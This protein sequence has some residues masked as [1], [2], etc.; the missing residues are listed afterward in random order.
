MERIRSLKSEVSAQSRALS[1][2]LRTAVLDGLAHAVKTPLTT[3]IVSSSGL[4]EVGSLTPLQ[5]ELADVIES[6]ASYLAEVTDKLLRTASLESRESLVQLTSA[7]I[8]VI[9]DSAISDLSLAYDTTRIHVEGMPGTPIEADPELL[10]MT[11]LQVLENALKYSPDS[12]PVLISFS[13]TKEEL[14]CSVYNH[15]SFIP[16]SEQSLIFERYYRGTSTAHKAN[17]T[18]IGLSVAQHAVEAHGGRI[19]VESDAETGTTFHI[20][21]PATPQGGEDASRVRTDR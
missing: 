13:Q 1:E 2:R 5:S 9:Y 10:R 14:R 12:S 17:G 7:R 18:G 8:D 19:W 11:L 4:R 20:T 6:Q 16:A 3:I 21:L 15:G